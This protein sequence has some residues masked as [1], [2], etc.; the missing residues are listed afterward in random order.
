VQ[1]TNSNSPGGA[2]QTM[3]YRKTPVGWLDAKY[4]WPK[5]HRVS[6]GVA[7][8][9]KRHSFTT[10]RVVTNQVAPHQFYGNRS[11][12]QYACIETKRVTLRQLIAF[13]KHM[14][15]LKLLKSAN[16]VKKELAVRLGE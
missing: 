10:A 3:P 7:V 9:L 8:A 12:E 5:C 13:G 6:A 2:L 14:N 11:V 1:D 16:Y 4:S 15:E